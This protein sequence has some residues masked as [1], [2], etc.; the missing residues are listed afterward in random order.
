MACK[1]GVALLN[2]LVDKGKDAVGVDLVLARQ[3]RCLQQG[4]HTRAQLLV[5][6][7]AKVTCS[8]L[9]EALGVHLDLWLVL[10]S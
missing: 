3:A 10:L 2:L 6:A 4:G 9:V 5:G 8:C 1:S 7:R